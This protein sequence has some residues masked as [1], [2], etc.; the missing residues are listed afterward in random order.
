MKFGQDLNEH[1]VPEWKTQYLDYKQGK[2]KL[3]QLKK[4]SSV[5]HSSSAASRRRPS[6]SVRS[7]AINSPAITTG[8]GVG[9]S[10]STS[11][12]AAVSEL[13][14]SRRRTSPVL[15][16]RGSTQ[17]VNPILET[18]HQFSPGSVGGG[19]FIQ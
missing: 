18:H 12:A 4:K 14:S 9:T 5:L 13:S 8:T 19:N 15:L 3:K 16:R 2:K 11:A 10:T 6:Q 1:L 17:A 7:N